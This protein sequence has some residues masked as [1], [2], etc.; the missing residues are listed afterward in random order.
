MVCLSLS[1][2]CVC[3]SE[4]RVCLFSLNSFFFFFFLSR[5]TGR[6]VYIMITSMHALALLQVALVALAESLRA[7]ERILHPFNKELLR[8]LRLVVIRSNLVRS[9]VWL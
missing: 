5:C 2:R 9:I 8:T 7:R 1:I 3:R 6:F 4:A